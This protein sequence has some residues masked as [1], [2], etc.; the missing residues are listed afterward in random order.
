MPLLVVA[1]LL[2]LAGAVALTLPVLQ[3]ELAIQQDA[4]EYTA[5]RE[6]FAKPDVPILTAS[7]GSADWINDV[8]APIAAIAESSASSQ[9]RT[10]VDLSACLAANADFIGWLQIPGTTVDYSV[11]QTD[12]IDYY[13]NHTFT[14]KKSYI[15]TLF[16]LG[17]TDFQ[18]P[19]RNI[20]VYGHHI[21]SNDEVM[22]SPLLAYKDEAFYA[23][24][25][26]VYLDTL[27]HTGTYTVFAVLNMKNGDWEPSTADF[28]SDHAYM[29]FIHRAKVQALYDTGIEVRASDRILTLITCDRSY[30]GKDGRL[31]VMAVR[32]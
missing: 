23:D 29:D 18:V 28:A 32:E 8:Q 21:R 9:G 31:V 16:S 2:L 22:F 25:A 19:S 27:Y 24:H 30:G 17:K 5:W 13:L 6:T 7:K 1:I 12:E 4:E 3:T 26:T 20:A 15:G 11:V 10:G 14:G